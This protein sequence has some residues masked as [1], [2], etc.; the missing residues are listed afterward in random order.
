M[1]RLAR[2]AAV[3][4][5]ALGLCGAPTGALQRPASAGGIERDLGEIGRDLRERGL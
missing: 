5:L 2:A 4:L 1:V 3:S